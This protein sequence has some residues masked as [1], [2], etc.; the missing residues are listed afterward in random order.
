M[1]A[2]QFEDKGTKESSAALRQTIPL[3]TDKLYKEEQERLKFSRM[4]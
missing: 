3:Q 4:S 1:T 2:G